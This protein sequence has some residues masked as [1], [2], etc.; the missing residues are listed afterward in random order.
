MVQILLADDHNM[1]VEG[2][3]M[4]LSGYP[5]FQVAA[6]AGNGSEALAIL[7]DTSIDI[8]VMDIN[9]PGM[10]G[11]QAT[12][13]IAAHFPEIHV[14]IL[15]MLGDEASVAKMLEAGARGYLFKNAGAEELA[16]AIHTVAEGGY[17][18]TAEMQPALEAFLKKKRSRSWG[19][20]PVETNPLSAREIEIV[21]HILAGQTNQE[22]AVELFLSPR[23]VDTHRKNILAKLQVKNTAALV[24]YATE[25]KAFLGL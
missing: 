6:I 3:K 2:L 1:F 13:E 22:I 19:L 5:G 23:T 8:V 15:S 16:A 7:R 9:M 24:K 25:K 10:S 12:I 4:L 17:F 21:R 11:Y 20:S 18:V 14:L